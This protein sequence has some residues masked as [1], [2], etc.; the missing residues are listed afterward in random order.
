MFGTGDLPRLDRVSVRILRH[1]GALGLLP[2]GTWP[3]E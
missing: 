2:L 3:R 1:Y